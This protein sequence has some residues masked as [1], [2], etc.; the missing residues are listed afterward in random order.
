MAV[1]D[2]IPAKP[3]VGDQPVLFVD[4]TGSDGVPANPTDGRLLVAAPSATE[5]TV[6]PFS[7]LSIAP[8]GLVGRVE[9]QMSFPLD[10]GGKWNFYWEFTS[11]VQ[12]AEPYGFV[13]AAR[14]VPDPAP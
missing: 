4:V 1:C 9:W 5:S 3:N 12:A 14:T 2:I 6:I 7:A 11:G 8:G 13:V 10:E